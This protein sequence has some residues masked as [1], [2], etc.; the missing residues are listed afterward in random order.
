[1]ISAE[2]CS[3]SPCYRCTVT[4]AL[5]QSEGVFIPAKVFPPRLGEYETQSG[6]C[7]RTQLQNSPTYL[8][9]KKIFILSSISSPAQL[10]ASR[11][12]VRRFG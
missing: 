11:F 12:F 7:P 3:Y 1:M 5:Q 4:A 9:R 8:N 10:A 2:F 6:F